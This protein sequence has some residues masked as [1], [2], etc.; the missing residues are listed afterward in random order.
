LGFAA[1]NNAG[2]RASKGRVLVLVNSDAFPDTGS[3]DRLVAALEELPDA[4][5]VGGLLRYPDGRFQAS[6]GKFPSL[7]GDLWV[8]LFLHRAPLLGRLEVGVSSHRSSYRVRRRVDWV[9]AAFCIARREAGLI[10]E[11]RF[12]YGEDVGWAAECRARGLE[13]W[14]E[15]SATA[16]HIGRA[17]VDRSQAPGFAQ[18]R[19][20]DFELRWFEPRGRLAAFAARAVLATHALMR[21]LV[22]ALPA[23]TRPRHR[24]HFLEYGALL[25]SA[26][27]GPRACSESG[28]RVSD[29]DA[30]R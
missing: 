2:I 10:P 4:G 18:R 17:S 28:R 23:L 9:T 16:V 6:M 11:S 20:V 5:I 1:A 14:L 24:R 15:P 21:M 26:L 12:M 22:Y 7:L 8:A 19:R 13:V 29:S 3:I 27:S 25:H 30:L